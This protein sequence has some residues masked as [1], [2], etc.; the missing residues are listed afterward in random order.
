MIFVG[1]AA[2]WSSKS[3]SSIRVAF[4]ENML[5]LTPPLERVAPR[6][7]LL[8]LLVIVVVILLPCLLCIGPGVAPYNVTVTGCTFQIS[9]QYSSMARSDENLPLRAVFRIDMRVHLSVSCH[10][11]PTCS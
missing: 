1:L 11:A 10:A 4:F 7:A 6:G 2:F 9:S 8:P 3:N 5:K